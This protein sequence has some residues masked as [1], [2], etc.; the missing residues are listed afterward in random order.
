ME[1]MLLDEALLQDLSLISVPILHFYEW[2]KPSATYGYFLDPSQF[3]NMETVEKTGLEL[4]R[5]PTGGG[6]VFHQCDLAFSVLIPACHPSFS[7]NPL[8]NYAFVHRHV[9]WAI[10]QFLKIESPT[11]LPQEEEPL[12]LA[13]R[14]F[15]MAKPTK[16]DVMIGGRKVGGAAQRKTRHGYLHQGSIAVG[17]LSDVYLQDIL[18]PATKVLE[19]MKRHSLSLLG[20]TWTPLQLEE[21]RNE[22]SRLLQQAFV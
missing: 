20:D 18:K 4:A 6:I 12:D 2:E 22:L 21:A 16:Y 15:C 11:L 10:E 3:L 1:N 17:L 13:C 14:H 8:D 19:G 5:R 9:I 7:L